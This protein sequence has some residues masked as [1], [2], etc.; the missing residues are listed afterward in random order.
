MTACSDTSQGMPNPK[1]LLADSAEP[2]EA[3]SK[4]VELVFGP[5]E[6]H[7]EKI[8]NILD[9]LAEPLRVAVVGR[10][11]AG[12][13]TLINS[14]VGAS[15]APTDALSCTKFVAWYRDDRFDWAQVRLLP[16]SDGAES[17]AGRQTKSIEWPPPPGGPIATDV[18]DQAI[19]DIH[20]WRSGLPRLQEWTVIDTPGYNDFEPEVSKRTR[21]VFI[22]ASIDA[23]VFVL[24]GAVAEEELA[25][26]TRV[27]A[28][29]AAMFADAAPESRSFP[30]HSS[31]VNTLAVLSRID[32]A[33]DQSDPFGGARKVINQ[34]ARELR[35][36]ATSVIPVLG[37]LAET[38]NQLTDDDCDALTRLKNLPEHAL[39]A[40][41]FQTAAPRAGLSAASIE[42]VSIMFGAYGLGFA[43][44][45]IR[46]HCITSRD[47]LRKV[48]FEHSGL[49]DLQQ[50]LRER[51]TDRTAALKARTA[52]RRLNSLSD[53]PGGL[54]KLQPYLARI[55]QL[56]GMHTL[57]EFDAY[58]RWQSGEVKL[59]SHIGQ[60]L[61]ALVFCRDPASRAG[62]DSAAAAEQIEKALW[63]RI[64]ECDE[65]LSERW[66]AKT[67]D[68]ARIMRRSYRLMLAHL[69]A[70]DR[71]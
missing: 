62:L 53:I 2:R 70:G 67:D 69:P 13:S 50:A 68:I 23:V 9:E 55:L 61:T 1:E 3:V 45:Q 20:V 49:G 4:V 57:R 52:V 29:L 64:G 47:E 66:S 63:Q 65:L 71:R 22:N 58:E 38:A 60:A 34:H 25:F 12:K 41:L 32:M 39:L 31:A 37:L 40:P 16:S 18:D 19:D 26:F 33:E 10:T 7:D 46:D 48:L 15:V 8:K 24:N 28:D 35:G 21:R 27:R 44:S 11:N 51:F 59:P 30:R 6:A 43:L 36:I 42:R 5:A 56:D 14:L 17:H 54:S